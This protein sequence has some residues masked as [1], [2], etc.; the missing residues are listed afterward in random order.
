MAGLLQP[1]AWV[2]VDLIP[3][4]GT[5]IV[6]QAS[7]RP[8]ADSDAY[9]GLKRGGILSFGDVDRSLSGRDG[10]PVVAT[11]D[12]EFFD[13]AGFWRGLQAAATT[14]Y[15]TG[16]E[17][18]FLLASIE[19]HTTEAAARTLFRGQLL[20][21]T[22]LPGRRYRLSAQSRVGSIKGPYDLNASI[23]KRTYTTADHP[24]LPREFD[25]RAVPF[26]W[27]EMSDLG[28]VNADGEDIATGMVIPT[29]CGAEFQGS[30]PGDPPTAPTYAQPPTN[31]QCVVTGSGTRIQA[32]IGVSF[33]TATGQTTVTRLVVD[34]YPA[35]PTASHYATWTWSDPNASG[36]VIGTRQWFSQGD[37]AI[38]QH[39]LDGTQ[40]GQTPTGPPSSSY[41]DDGDDSH[42]KTLWGPPP[43]TNTAQIAPGSPGTAENSAF[44][45]W[46]NL[47]GH[48]GKITAAYVSDLAEGEASYTPLTADDIG[49]DWTTGKPFLFGT[50]G[51]G[52]T[53]IVNGRCYFGFW[54]LV[55][56]PRVEAHL[57]NNMPIRVNLCGWHVD[58]D[59]ANPIIDQAA[60]VYQD[61]IV[62]LSGNSGQGYQSGD[63]LTIPNFAGASTVPILQSTT[64]ATVQDVSKVYLGDTKGYVAC[65]YLDSLDTKWREF[66]E[67]MNRG[68]HFDSGE[69]HHGQQIISVMDDESDPDSG[70]LLR[71]GIEI[72]RVEDAGAVVDAEIEN[73]VR[74]Q[75][76]KHPITGEYRSGII[77]IRDQESIDRYGER[78]GSVIDMPYTRDPTTAADVAQRYLID[79]STGP[80]YPS[81]VTRFKKGLGVE[82]G[83]QIR[84][85]HSDL[86]TSDPVPIYVRQQ[87]VS[88]GQGEVTLKGR[89]RT[90][91]LAEAWNGTIVED[92]DPSTTIGVIY[93][94]A[95]TGTL[96]TEIR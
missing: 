10:S 95:A 58:N 72:L 18:A 26:L 29:A 90:I 11:F 8:Y 20:S 76:D 7:I 63:R 6:W 53:R 92:A 9:G 21:P 62:Q 64:F 16:Q 89:D 41:V 80:T 15:L 46:F 30:T 60:L 48:P 24:N 3:V 88:T 27:G 51:N 65:V 75:F 42:D 82:L 32:T 84:I 86:I 83:G 50:D 45:I 35:S 1:T 68:F 13:R 71:E 56:E 96:P 78:T 17:V 47:L 5:P 67:G 14:R 40:P 23:L 57:K 12:F 25:G 94:D 36:I 79:R 54:G 52:V 74:Y 69:N 22:P 37:V 77:T 55:G 43:T 87:V 49:T 44:Y 31:L 19:A 61:V 2:R 34:S 66:F 73:V 4:D 81:V 28:T 38:P 70:T 59:T 33:V 85:Q 39:N 93:E 91:L